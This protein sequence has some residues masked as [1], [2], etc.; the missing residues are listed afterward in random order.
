MRCLLNY[1]TKNSLMPTYQSGYRQFHSTETVLSH[2]LSSLFAAADV[3]IAPRYM[4]AAFDCVDHDILLTRLHCSYGV[5][6]AA[7]D[8]FRS[9]LTN[10]TRQV[11]FNSSVSDVA[12][13][14]SRVPQGSVMG[15]ILFLLYTYD[16]IKIIT[17]Y[18]FVCHAFADDIQILITNPPGLFKDEVNRYN[19]CMMEIGHWMLGNSLKVN[20]CKTQLLPVGT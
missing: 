3:F 2:V 18:G 1:L 15:P 14:S 5:S 13:V 17:L 8:W 4:S 10:R 20:K 19:E 11:A 16:I 9:Y 7:H 6:G 12:L